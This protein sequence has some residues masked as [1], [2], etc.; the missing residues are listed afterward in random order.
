[1]VELF[2]ID[3]ELVWKSAD[4]NRDELSVFFVFRRSAIC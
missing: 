2:Q 1:M 3:V 4:W